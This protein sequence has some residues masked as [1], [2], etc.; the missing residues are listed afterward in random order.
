[1]EI[2]NKLAVTTRE[3]GIMREKRER[4]KSGSVYK[5][6]MDVD[7]RVGIDCGSRGEQWGKLGQ[8]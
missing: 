7:S 4:V 2:R 5:G 8:L 3:G 1:M 6:P